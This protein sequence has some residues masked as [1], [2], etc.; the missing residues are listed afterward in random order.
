MAGA[1]SNGNG[2]FANGNGAGPGVA[3]MKVGSG[4]G[5]VALEAPSTDA[6]AF[7]E[8]QPIV[9]EAPG[10]EWGRF[11]TYSTF[12]VRAARRSRALASRSA[13]P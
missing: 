3:L 12:A 4:P 13:R 5:E 11:K 2:G 6:F 8:N 7:D 10:G 9:A 1:S